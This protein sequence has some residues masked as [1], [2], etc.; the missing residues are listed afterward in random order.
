MKNYSASQA[1]ASYNLVLYL[2]SNYEIVITIYEMSPAMGITL[3][4]HLV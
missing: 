3:V 2:A 1:I 4:H